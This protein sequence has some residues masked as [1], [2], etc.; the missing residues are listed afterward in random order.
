MQVGYRYALAMTHHVEDAEDLVHDSWLKLCRRYGQVRSCA[1]LFTTIRHLFIDQYRRRQIVA[2]ESIDQV[3]LRNLPALVTE[4]AGLKGDLDCLLAILRPNERE[5][6]FLCYCQGYT[7]KQIA[8]ATG[9]P[10][11]TVLSLINRSIKKLRG[12][13]GEAFAAP[14][15]IDGCAGSGKQSKPLANQRALGP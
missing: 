4:E 6:L 3:E 15:S 10:R 1:V 12:A 9:H 11:G 13:A 8:E 5:I 7:A 2:F 14:W